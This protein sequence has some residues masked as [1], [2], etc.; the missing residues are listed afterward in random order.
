MSDP[1]LDDRFS[2]FLLRK[3][4]SNLANLLGSLCS[5]PICIYFLSPLQ[6]VQMCAISGEFLQGAP[7]EQNQHFKKLRH[8]R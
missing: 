3:V 1:S 2:S 4:R 7:N 5:V 8:I 6:T